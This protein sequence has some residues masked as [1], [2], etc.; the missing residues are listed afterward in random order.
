M[1]IIGKILGFIFGSMMTLYVVFTVLNFFVKAGQW[2]GANGR[3]IL[4]VIGVVIA[5]VIIAVVS[6]GGSSL[7]SRTNPM[8]DCRYHNLDKPVRF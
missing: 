2:L 5:V 8:G 4:T 7:E 6:G 1:E 3:T